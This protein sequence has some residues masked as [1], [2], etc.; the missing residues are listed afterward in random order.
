MEL[1]ES[2]EAAGAERERPSNIHLIRTFSDNSIF[3]PFEGNLASPAY[4]CVM[5]T[6]SFT[7]IM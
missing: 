6:L 5:G 7:S 4:S 2:A 3:T 1:A